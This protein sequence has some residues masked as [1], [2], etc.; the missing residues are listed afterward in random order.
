MMT[1]QHK[2]K[3]N[4]SSKLSRHVDS[5]FSLPCYISYVD[6]GDIS[7]YGGDRLWWGHILATPAQCA[8]KCITYTCTLW[9]SHMLVVDTLCQGQPVA[10]PLQPFSAAKI[11]IHWDRIIENNGGLAEPAKWQL[12]MSGWKS[13]QLEGDRAHITVTSGALLSLTHLVI[14][15]LCICS[16]AQV[17]WSAEYRCTSRS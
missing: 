5:P 10:W 11:Y 7:S 12:T 1:I 3:T 15:S 6:V 4:S 9:S 8:G 13:I 14:I 16:T 17:F 2:H